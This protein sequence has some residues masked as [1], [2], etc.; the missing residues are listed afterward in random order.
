MNAVFNYW[1]YVVL[2][3]YCLSII[4]LGLWVSRSKKGVEKTTSDYF[5]AGKT[6]PWWAI[7]SSL[8]A[9]NISAEQF[10]GMSGSGF[11]IGL[12]IASYEWMAAITL[13]IVAKYFL[14]VFIEKKLFTIPEFIEQRYSTTLK[15]ILA[16]FWIALFVLV[17]LTT[18]LFLGAKTLDTI[19]GDGSGSL[20]MIGIFGLA[21][22][23]A[24]YSLWGG[25]SAVAWTDVLQVV[26]LIGGGLATTFIALDHLTPDGG[27]IA[28][29]KHL[30]AAVP[31]KFSMILSKGE[32]ITPNGNDAYNDLPGLA[33]LLGGLW[34]ANLYYWG[35]N[36]YI[37]QRTLAAKTLRE[38]QKGM[39]FA[40]FLKLL[41]PLIVVIPGIIAFMMN[42]SP[43]HQVVAPYANDAFLSA[44]G[45][46]NDRAFPWLI[47]TFI[48]TGVKGLIL[49]ALVAAIVSSLA[50]MLNST[51]TIF[52]MDLY[53]PYLRP[54]ASEKQM[55][56][57]GRISASVA[58]VIAVMIAP[59]LGNLKQA[60]Q[61]IQ[62]YTG[63][64]SPGILAIFLMG[65]FTKKATNRAAITGALFS[66]LLAMFLKAGPKGW[67]EGTAF[68][69]LL[70]VLPWMHQ[71][72][73][74]C[75]ATMA[76]IYIFSL[77]ELKGRNDAKA[78]PIAKGLFKT[79]PSFN[80]AATAI[81]LILIALYALFW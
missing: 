57:T 44:T 56:R 4:A 64:V 15:S 36:Q 39:V 58:L 75:L 45:V 18:V 41:I 46:D 20:I 67:G 30:Y 25:L 48:P 13:V 23:A 31:E 21:L 38:A 28:G 10:I 24:T 6:L 54:Q 1:D 16:V 49:A 63:V 40:G 79:D 71:M 9:A 72:M 81:I 78:M 5:L 2:A 8:I 59:M 3:V 27:I 35:F 60:F 50:S 62:E 17:N 77:I 11:A 33:V 29:I 70:P 69:A 14:P 55:V 42:S 66:I 76:F 80:I 47:A 37:I 61:Y 7:G 53:K 68:E 74:T 65:L 34:V 32:M 51:A 73:I 43:D 52:T 19:A 26:L 12:A 22:F